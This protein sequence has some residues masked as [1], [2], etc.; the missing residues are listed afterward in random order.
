M[1]FIVK[2]DMI[3]ILHEFTKKTLNK[4]QRTKGKCIRE[5]VV[6]KGFRGTKS[7]PIFLKS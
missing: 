1:T 2:D 6:L 4:E 3:I 7:V 5:N